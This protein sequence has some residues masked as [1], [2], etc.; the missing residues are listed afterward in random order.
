MKKLNTALAIGVASLVGIVAVNAVNAAGNTT[1]PTAEH[2]LIEPCRAFDATVNTGKA[3]NVGL[4]SCVPA[5]VT[6]VKINITGV[7]GAT[8]QWVQA[9]ANLTTFGSSSILNLSPGQGNSN[10]ADLASSGGTIQL[11]VG[12]YQGSTVR[13]VVDVLGYY[14]GGEMPPF[15]QGS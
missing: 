7:G 15:P 11:A 9:G 5:G 1:S 2:L 3:F 13:L 6:G 10:T 8:A 4:N 12:P 14:T